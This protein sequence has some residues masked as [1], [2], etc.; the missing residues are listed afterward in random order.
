MGIK[1]SD[2]VSYIIEETKLFKK[3]DLPDNQNSDVLILLPENIEEAQDKSNFIFADSTNDFRKVLKLNNISSTIIGNDNSQFRIRKSADLYG[4]AIFIT[5]SLL[6][7]NPHLVSIS[8]N[9]ISD[10][11]IDWFKGKTGNKNVKLSI[12]VETQKSKKVMK[13]SYEGNP[14]GIKKLDK[15]VKSLSR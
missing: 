3:L 11:C 13:I 2:I 10:Y 15:V 12:Y 8:L 14:E 5:L 4:P 9:I 7:E 6:S 1:K